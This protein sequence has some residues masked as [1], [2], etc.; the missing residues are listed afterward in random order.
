MSSSSQHLSL[1]GG[2][3][4]RYIPNWIPGDQ[5]ARLF[6]T[7]M[8]EVPWRQEHFMMGARR[9]QQPRLT[10]WVGEEG[11][12]Y[13]SSRR[14]FEPSPWSPHLSMVRDRLRDDLGITTNSVLCNLYRTGQDSMGCHADDEPELGVNP[15]IAS[16]SLGETRKMVF[17][18]AEK[19]AP[20]VEL[21][22]EGG[23][24]LIMAGTLQHH[25]RHELPKTKRVN[26]PRI[27]LTYRQ[28]LSARA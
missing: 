25:W 4:I 3:T 7:L 10:A 19:A 8:T 15:T 21:M 22:L 26:A 14:V 24:L 13:V 20:K 27:N 9:I 12:R 28:F 1:L 17:R 23:S 2:G 18:H 6:D 11:M 16:I 5:A